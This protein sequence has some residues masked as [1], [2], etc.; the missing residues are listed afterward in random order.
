MTKTNNVYT[1][2]IEPEEEILYHTEAVYNEDDE[3]IGFRHILDENGNKIPLR[4]CICYAR[5]PSECGCN[6]NSWG[7]YRYDDDGWYEEEMSYGGTY[8]DYF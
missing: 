2:D 8:Y 5:E 7:D 3:P 1:Q 6:C 4:I